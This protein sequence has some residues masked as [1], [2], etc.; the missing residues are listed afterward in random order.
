[1]KVDPSSDFSRPLSEFLRCIAL[2]L[3]VLQQDGRSVEDAIGRSILGEEPTTQ[4][5]LRN[6][7]GIDLIVQSLGELRVFLDF[8]NASL[9]NDDLIDASEVLGTMGLRELAY[10]LSS[11]T[12]QLVLDSS[13]QVSGEVD[14]F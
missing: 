2:E 7:Q 11:G 5:V 3:L 1:M 13:G 14:L 10:R 4:D 8:L 12:R 9:M 6:L